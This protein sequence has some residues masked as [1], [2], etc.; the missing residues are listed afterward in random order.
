MSPVL[1]VPWLTSYA[2]LLHQN[3]SLFPP[4][5]VSHTNRLILSPCLLLPIGSLA[6]QVRGRMTW[7]WVVVRLHHTGG[8]HR[9]D[10][11]RRHN[12][13]GPEGLLVHEMM[14]RN[15]HRDGPIQFPKIPGKSYQA[16]SP[17]C[18]IC[19]TVLAHPLLLLN[20][21]L[22]QALELTFRAR[23]RLVLPPSHSP[24]AHGHL[25]PCV[26]PQRRYILGLLRLRP[27]RNRTSYRLKDGRSSAP[28]KQPCNWNGNGNKRRNAVANWK[29]LRPLRIRSGT[30]PMPP[31]HPTI[32]SPTGTSMVTIG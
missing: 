31:P 26:L 19:W 24:V 7:S 16:A 14:F 25:F 29:R 30:P 9:I 20:L 27:S 12:P 11:L 28:V 17:S 18:M 15:H 22:L 2:N 13:L 4:A 3:Q 23:P 1:K 10:M 8:V 32:T 6:C 5:H 21:L